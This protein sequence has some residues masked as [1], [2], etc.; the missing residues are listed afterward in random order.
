MHDFD[1]TTAS[2]PC[3][4]TDLTGS[5]E[6]PALFRRV[7]SYNVSIEQGEERDE[8]TLEEILSTF[9]VEHKTRFEEM[10]DLEKQW[11]KLIG[12]I[13]EVGVSC[14]GQDMMLPLLSPSSPL[15]SLP[16][17]KKG[18]N[19]AL[20]DSTKSGPVRKKV[21][22]QEPEPELPRFLSTSTHHAKM[23]LL[24]PISDE[25]VKNLEDKIDALGVHQVEEFVRVD[26]ESKQSY[27]K[28]LR[29]VL[30]LLKDE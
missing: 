1:A 21:K 15:S 28:K 22:F 13:W 17:L 7:G 2:T 5:P 25:D 14:L 24:E 10:N 12:E 6:E 3:H 18:E 30:D 27:F 11:E 29:E 26:E 4:T 20:D 23:P 19:S 16:A 9:A 8:K